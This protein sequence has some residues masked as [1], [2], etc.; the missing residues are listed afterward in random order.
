VPNLSILS[1]NSD[2]TSGTRPGGPTPRAMVADNDLAL[3]RIV[4]GISKS[5]IWAH[6]LI[7]VVEDDAQ[8]GVDHVDG[9]RTIALAIGP[10]IRR[11]AVDSNNY[12]QVS[13]IRTIQEIFRIPARTRYLAAARPMTSIFTAE[14]DPAAYEHLVPKPSLDE[15]NPPLKALSGRRLWAARQSAAMNFRDLDDAPEDTLNRV[16][17]W[18]AKGYDTPYPVRH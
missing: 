16:L 14:A 7:L 9:H 12:N 10:F 18:D 4:E 1:L 2:H 8:D 13:L 11:N 3:G 6:S 15:S 5:R 17:W